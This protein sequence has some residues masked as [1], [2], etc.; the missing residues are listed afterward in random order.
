MQFREFR[1]TEKKAGIH[2]RRT[3]S[4]LDREGL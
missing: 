2:L 3:T 1:T 4:T